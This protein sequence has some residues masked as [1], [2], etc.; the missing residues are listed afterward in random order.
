MNQDKKFPLYLIHGRLGAGKTSLIS[1]LAATEYFK[2]AFVIE[3]EFAKESVDGAVLGSR[4]GK[5]SIF[6]ISGGCICCSSGAELI[7]V[8]EAIRK[9]KGDAPVP[10]IVE[11]TGVASSV[12]LLKQ[13]LLSDTFHRYFYL[14]K[15]ILVVDALETEPAELNAMK[16]DVALADLVVLSKKDLVDDKKLAAFQDTITG[17]KPD[18]RYVPVADGVI[19]PSL[20]IDGRPSGAE[21]VLVENI[22]DIA[23][24]LAVDHS[25]DVQYRI[26]E[27]RRPVTEQAFRDHLDDL[28]RTE[29]K[30]YRVKGHFEDENGATVRVEATPHHV[31]FHPASS[32][33]SRKIVVIGR[34]LPDDILSFIS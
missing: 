31:A 24:V 30:L 13:L 22:S 27:A 17:I 10:V 2:H 20:I 25:A 12:Q 11:T 1:R 8:L 6:E 21:H 28:R 7:D 15:N 29:V 3:N 5:K 34:E 4:F 26:I 19:D 14:A 16:L 23:D 9:Q 18:A 33:G 32:G